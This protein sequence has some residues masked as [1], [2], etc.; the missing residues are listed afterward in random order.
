MSRGRPDILFRLSVYALF[1]R[2][3]GVLIG[4][5]WGILGIA[6]AYVLGVYGCVLYPTWSAAGRL[7]GLRFMEILRNVTGVLFC[8]M[9]MAIMVWLVDRLLLLEK[10]RSLRLAVGFIVGVVFYTLL[11][12][13]FRLQAWNDIRELVIEIGGGRKRFIRWLVGDTA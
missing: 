7:I 12:R 13:L 1:I 9:G 4:M 8:G 11:I 2:V 10:A 3:A 5:H 6:W